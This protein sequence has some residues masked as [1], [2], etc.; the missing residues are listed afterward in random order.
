MVS[1]MSR[2]VCLAELGQALLNRCRRRASTVM[3]LAL[4]AALAVS[5]AI[6]V[7]ALTGTATASTAR[8]AR[9]DATQVSVTVRGI[10]RHGQSVSMAYQVT[11]VS[12][13]GGQSY[14][15]TARACSRS[16][17]ERM[18]LVPRPDGRKRR[19]ASQPDTRCP[20]S[21]GSPKHHGDPGR[22]CGPLVDVSLSQPGSRPKWIDSSLCVSAGGGVELARDQG[23]G[24]VAPTPLYVVPAS[25]S[26]ISFG[27][28][29]DWQDGPRPVLPVRWQQGRYTG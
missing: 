3:G 11:A 2:A 14:V 16:R 25:D 7:P 17:P 6:G 10:D 8:T 26:R 22:T 23:W 20:D 28:V 19:P 24:T 13:T 5:A 27:F 18:R 4:P 21:A 12:L 9:S 1:V 29:N 15:P